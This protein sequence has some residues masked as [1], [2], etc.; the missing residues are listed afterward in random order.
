VS[1]YKAIGG[2]TK[3]LMFLI[4]HKLNTRLDDISPTVLSQNPEKFLQ[5]NTDAINVHLYHI[6]ENANMKNVFLPSRN[7]HGAKM[8]S[9]YLTLDLYY[10]IMTR[11]DDDLNN[12]IMLGHALLSLFENPILDKDFF[13]D[14]I[15]IPPVNEANISTDNLESI[16]ITMENLSLDEASKVWSM[17]GMKYRPC[18]YYKVSVVLMREMKETAAGLPVKEYLID[19]E[20]HER[21]QIDT[22]EKE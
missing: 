12:D 21:I 6:R 20:Q 7:K 1:S 16:K 19:I 4:E 10:T 17:Y 5:S 3:A 8:N 14:N 18:A 11:S 22:I 13:S 15:E 2:I 9:S